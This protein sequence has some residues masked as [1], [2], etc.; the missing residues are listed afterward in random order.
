MDASGHRFDKRA[1]QIGAKSR[2][3][4]MLENRYAVRRNSMLTISSRFVEEPVEIGTEIKQIEAEAEYHWLR[5]AGNSG[6]G[7]ELRCPLELRETVIT[8]YVVAFCCLDIALGSLRS[9]KARGVMISLG[10]Q[11]IDEV[12]TNDLGSLLHFRFEGVYRFVPEAKV[13]E[14]PVTMSSATSDVT[15]TSVY[16]DSEPGRAFW[17]ADYE[18]I[19]E[20][21]IP[22]VIVLGYDG[23]PLQPVAPPSPDFMLGPE[24]PQTPP[25]P[26]DEDE[27]E[28]MFIQAHNPDYVPEPIYPEYIPLEDDHEFPAEEQPLPP[29]DSPT[30]ESPGYVTESDPEEDPEEYEDDET[31]DGPV[32]YPMDGGDDGDDGDDDDGEFIR[33]DDT[34]IHL[35]SLSIQKHVLFVLWVWCL[36]EKWLTF[37]QGLRNTN[38]TQTLDLADIHERFVYEENLIQ[39]RYDTKKA[40]ITTPLTTPI[41]TAFF[42]NHVLQDFQENSNDEVDERTSLVSK[43]FDWD[44]EEVLDDEELT[45]VKVLMALADDELIVGKNHAHNVESIDI[46]LRK[47]NIVLSMDKDAD[48]KNYL[49]YINVDLN[50]AVNECVKPTKASNDP[51]SSKDSESESLTLLSPL[52]NLHGASLSSKHETQESSNKCVSG[53]VTINDTEPV[54]PSV[55]TEVKN[56][57]QES[58]INELIK[59]VQML[60]D[61]KINSKTHEQKPESSNSGSSSKKEDHR[62]LI[63]D[64]YTASLKR[65][66]NYKAQPYQYASP[67]KQILKAKAKPFPL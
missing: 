37:S 53:P 65:S 4:S 24:D 54:T 15:Y 40:L 31:E 46:T 56:T 50:Q 43:T 10:L 48:W 41:S 52:K 55:R 58:K 62:T 18:E 35:V 66:E 9:F 1:R 57:E 12:N 59:L 39:R 42:S 19:S 14:K 34:A 38:H 22:R 67:S 61:E 5:F 6:R 26:Q 60:M 7:P 27:R 8:F 45:Q 30:T 16:S 23:L 25:V 17:G 63:Y 44:E 29:V 28:P 64:M 3:S 32:D 2:W 49:K 20:G 36:P 11:Y 47:V 13:I 51:E 21:G 33:E